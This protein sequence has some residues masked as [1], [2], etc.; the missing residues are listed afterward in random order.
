MLAVVHKLLVR[1]LVT[2]QLAG[3]QEGDSMV[4]GTTVWD[5]GIMLAQFIAGE[6]NT[7]DALC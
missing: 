1:P 3:M 6:L 4:T 7:L 2:E 5:A